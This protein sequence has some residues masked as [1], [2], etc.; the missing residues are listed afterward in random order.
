M[1]EV[2][3][4]TI[5]TQLTSGGADHVTTTDGG[6]FQFTSTVKLA[7]GALPQFTV[8]IDGMLQQPSIEMIDGIVQPTI[9]IVVGIF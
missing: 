8:M 9:L 2:G 4:L 3:H 1:V 7:V 6:V 5:T